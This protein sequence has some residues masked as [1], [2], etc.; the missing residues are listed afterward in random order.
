[1]SDNTLTLTPADVSPEGTIN[2]SAVAADAK[3][4]VG[5]TP[6]GDIAVLRNGSNVMLKTGEP[7]LKGDL[8]LPS[9]ETGN[10]LIMASNNAGEITEV[11]LPADQSVALSDD[12][13]STGDAVAVAEA[14]VEAQETSGLF[15]G[16]AA[17]AGV[18]SGG[19]AIGLAA[20]GVAAAGGGGGGGD[21][22]SASPAPAPS[23]LNPDLQ[24]TDTN[25]GAPPPASAPAGP[26]SGGAAMLA[27]PLGAIPGV[28]PQI[29]D[30]LLSGA[31]AL[32]A[33]PLGA[34]A[35]AS[36]G[37]P[38]SALTASLAGGQLP[39]PTALAGPV[40]DLLAVAGN[41][42]GISSAA[43][44]PSAPPLPAAPASPV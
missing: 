30:G 38:L 40:E 35:P 4:V 25:G 43:A 44:D 18:S 24:G 37:N 10:T 6:S 11:S 7:V 28:G 41:A 21:S 8:I 12:F 15:G 27:E 20:I 13:Y 14:D 29:Q 39:L 31:A 9:S 5:K 34:A 26:F 42:A 3:V 36:S 1:M 17:A 16:L 19:A 32:D 33:S 2:N 22:G 23:P